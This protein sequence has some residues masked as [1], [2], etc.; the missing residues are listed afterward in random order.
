FYCQA[1]RDIVHISPLVFNSSNTNTSNTSISNATAADIF[2]SSTT[3][4]FVS[5]TPKAPSIQQ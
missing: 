5:T 1:L 4:T 2:T 3:A